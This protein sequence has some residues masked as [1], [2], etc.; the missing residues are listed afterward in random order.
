MGS[1]PEISYFLTESTLN[2]S[3]AVPFSLGSY[4]IFSVDFSD[5]SEYDLL[6]N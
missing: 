3:V 4:A 5:I 1:Y 6:D 2:I